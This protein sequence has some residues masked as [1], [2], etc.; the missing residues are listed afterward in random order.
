MFS[1][2]T[3]FTQRNSSLSNIDTRLIFSFSSALMFLLHFYYKKFKLWK[4]YI[5]HFKD[6]Q[7]H[8]IY[9]FLFSKRNFELFS[10]LEQIKCS[11]KKVE[12][13]G[14]RRKAHLFSNKT[15]VTKLGVLVKYNF[16]KFTFWVVVFVDSKSRDLTLKFCFSIRVIFSFLK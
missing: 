15:I 4:F 7:F 9:F 13:G 1:N 3:I 5:L 6:F 16:K 2:K 8:T 10:H 12:I 14:K 11:E